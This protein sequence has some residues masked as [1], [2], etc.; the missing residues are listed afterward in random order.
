MFSP[1]GTGVEAMDKAGGL[2]MIHSAVKPERL[3]C[4]GLSG[5]SSR[6]HRAAIV[7]CLEI[8]GRF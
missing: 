1:V 6:T 3:F 5:Y 2:F 7:T 8:R 4:A